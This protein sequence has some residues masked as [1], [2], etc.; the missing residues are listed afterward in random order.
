[1]QTGY[2]IKPVKW[3]SIDTKELWRF[4]ELFWFMAWRDIKIKYKQTILG[5][6]WVILQPLIL[7]LVFNFIWLKVVKLGDVGMPYPLFA[8]SGLIFWGLF[9]SAVSGSSSSMLANSNIIKKVYF[10]RIIIPS[11]AVL[12]SLFDFAITLIIYFLL[13][14]FYN[15]DISYLRLFA[16]LPVS[17]SITLISSYGIG[18]IIASLTIK[19][20][21]FKYLIP[22]FLQA[23][24][25]ISPVI[26][27]LT[28]YD[29]STLQFVLSINPLAGAI[30]IAR[31]ALAGTPVEW[32]SVLYGLLAAL[33]LLVVGI[34]LFRKMD[35]YY[36]DLL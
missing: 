18:L 12:V 9:S 14:L 22:F 30:N 6:L 11:S 27:P 21:D 8:L 16:L 20:R 2:E 15:P 35:I 19:Y 5:F 28:I 1:M 3:L 17:I 23:Y 24:F 36:T 31:S 32:I 29:N 26:I 7:M 33:L 25:F 10:P 34:T 4:R 13:I